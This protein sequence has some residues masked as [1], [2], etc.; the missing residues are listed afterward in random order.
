MQKLQQ[1]HSKRR[2]ETRGVG[3]SASAR[4][5]EGVVRAESSPRK[6]DDAALPLLQQKGGRGQGQAG[7]KQSLEGSKGPRYSH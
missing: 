6:R 5:H 7:L 4:R 3:L 2:L 1:V